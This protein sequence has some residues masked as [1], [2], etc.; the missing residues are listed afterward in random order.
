MA[1]LRVTTLDITLCVGFFQNNDNQVNIG[2][3]IED[4]MTY[5][6]HVYGLRRKFCPDACPRLHVVLRVILAR[7]WLRMQIRQQGRE[8]LERL[9]C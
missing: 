6:I 5:M 3:P 9:A 7:K 2:D 1:A 8:T 4:I